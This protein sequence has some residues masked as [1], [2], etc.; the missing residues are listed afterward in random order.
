LRHQYHNGSAGLGGNDDA[1]QMSAWYLFSAL[2]FY[3]VAPGSTQYSLGSPLVKE[4]TLQFENGKTLNIKA[5]N[6]SNKNVYVKSVMLNG[7]KLEGNFITH[8]ALMSGGTLVF[9]MSNRP[10]K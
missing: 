2:G 1:G 10:S 6:Q 5:L 3:P 7:K 8:N 4:A 9:Q